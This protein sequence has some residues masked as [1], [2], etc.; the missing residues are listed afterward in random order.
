[1]PTLGTYLRRIETGTFAGDFDVGEQFHNYQLHES[2]RACHGTEIPRDLVNRLRA[3]SIEVAKIMRWC[4]LPFGWQAAPYQ[5]LRMLAHLFEI[6]KGRPKDAGSAFAWVRTKLNL[7]GMDD[8]DPF[9]P[10]VMKLR[11]D[12]RLAADIIAF[13]DDGRV[14]GP[15][16]ALARQAPT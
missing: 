3:E 10:S 5:A 2:E 8:Y 13:Y 14:F 12:N 9:R 4:R 11:P 6:A 7:P 16:A 15:D 1:M